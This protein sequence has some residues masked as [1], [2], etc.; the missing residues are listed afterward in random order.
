[1]NNLKKFGVIISITV[2][3]AIF[4]FSLI[5]AVQEKPDYSDFCNSLSVPV[6]MQVENLNCPEA[7][8]SELDAESCQSER[9][10]YIPKYETGCITNYECE[11]CFRDYNLA[12]KNHNFLTFIISTILGLIVVLLSIYLPHKKDSLKEWVL[13]GLLLGGLIA[14]FIGT[15]QYFS[16]LHRILRPIVILL[17]IV[18]IIFVAYKKMKK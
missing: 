11:T 1:M 13:I 10:D 4:I 6:K 2:L 7:N 8:F 9:G 15:G 17:E 3:F 16:D 18:L 5:T 14:I 12:Q